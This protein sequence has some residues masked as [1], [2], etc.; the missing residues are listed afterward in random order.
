MEI[1]EY[2]NIGKYDIL[3]ICK[4]AVADTATYGASSKKKSGAKER[5]EEP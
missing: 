2:T 3:T 5:W 4:Q 1:Q